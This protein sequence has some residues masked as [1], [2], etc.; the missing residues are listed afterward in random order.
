MGKQKKGRRH[1]SVNRTPRPIGGAWLPVAGE[2]H[3]CLPQQAVGRQ[4]VYRDRVDLVDGRAYPVTAL[5]HVDGKPMR[6]DLVA[7]M[8][9]VIQGEVTGECADILASL[10]FA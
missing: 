10:A 4:P 3:S 9:G 1:R 8:H 5:L 7:N 2:S 6:F